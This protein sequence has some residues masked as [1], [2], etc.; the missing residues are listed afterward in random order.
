MPVKESY[1]SGLS[2]IYAIS[3]LHSIGLDFMELPFIK[4]SPSSKSKIPT[5]ALIVV[6]FPAP[7]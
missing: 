2:G 6:V 4:I 5:T 7:L 1:K 3:F